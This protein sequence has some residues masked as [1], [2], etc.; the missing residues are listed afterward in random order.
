MCS[1]SMDSRSLLQAQMEPPQPTKVTMP[2]PGDPE[3]LNP[4]ALNSFPGKLL[5]ICRQI[6]ELQVLQKVGDMGAAQRHNILC[7]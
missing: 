4:E 1:I 5:P 6:G 3:A 2:G 7:E